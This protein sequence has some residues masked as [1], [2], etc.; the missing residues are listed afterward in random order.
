[1]KAFLL[2]LVACAVI[3]A[4]AGIGLEEAGFTAQ[5]STTVGQSVRLDGNGD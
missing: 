4:V 2:A 5:E 1:M 3:T